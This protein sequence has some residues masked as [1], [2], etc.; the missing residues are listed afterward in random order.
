MAQ[1]P[2]LIDQIQIE[3]GS[4]GTRLIRRAAA[5]GALEFLDAQVTGGVSLLNLAG[6]KT[7]ANVLVVGKS[8]AGAAY[9]TV[10]AALDAIPASSS[11]SNPY[12]VFVGPGQYRETLNLARDGVVIQG[13]G[14]VLQSAVE[15]TPDAPGAYHTFVI[16]EALG[17]VPRLVILR[18]LTITNAHNNYACVRVVGGAASMVG[19]LG[20]YLNNCRLEANSA[21][22]NHPLWASTMNV[23]RIQGGSMADTSGL[24]TL[25]VEECSEA[26]FEGLLTPPPMSLRWDVTNPVPSASHVGYSVLNVSRLGL[27][28]S[29][30]PKLALTSSAA[31]NQGSLFLASLS[32]GTDPSLSVTNGICQAVGCELGAISSTGAQV[33]L[34]GSHYGVLTTASGGKI[35]RERTFG[36]ESFAGESTKTVALAATAGSASYTVLLETDVVP[37][38]PGP[39]IEGKTES[40]FEI[41]FAGVE[42]LTVN[43]TVLH[44]D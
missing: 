8:G 35:S 39:W 23:L 3:P 19:E 12:F 17:T 20:V 30:S 1:N 9:T 26:T 27:G 41:H 44:N 34:R 36:T 21:G 10:Q 43:W 38:N 32:G 40:S 6:L 22:G 18:D 5:T 7:M 28:S 15:G 33:S 11:P 24:S 4:A 13:F 14:A 2:L 29:L 31:P 42:T 16:Q 37:A 25:R